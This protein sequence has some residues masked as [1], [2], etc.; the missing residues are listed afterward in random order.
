MT[1]TKTKIINI[2]LI[3]LPI[4]LGIGGAVQTGFK[5]AFVKDY[6]YAVRVDADGQHD[7]SYI[8]ELLDLVI[9]DRFDITIGS[10]FIEPF[11]GYRSSF[12][13]RIGIN[14]FAK[15]ISLIT[16]YNVT[17]PTSCFQVYNKKAIKM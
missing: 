13:R 10:R 15:L 2:C 3:N 7:V 5:Y 14:F 17:D 4:N 8:Q 6:D 11:T 9:S 1:D 12:I 16:N